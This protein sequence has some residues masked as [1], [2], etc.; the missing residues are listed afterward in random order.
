M[1]ETELNDRER[2]LTTLIRKLQSSA[3]LRPG[4]QVFCEQDWFD[5]DHEPYAHFAHYRKPR[6]GDL[7]IGQTGRIDRWKIGFYVSGSGNGNHV[8]RDINT[9]QLCNYGNEEFV[10]I[11][12]LSKTDLLTGEERKVY[13]K[14]LK[15]FDRGDEYLYRFGGFEVEGDTITITIRERHNGMGQPS[16]PFAVRMKWN[17]RTTVKAILE[18]M[19]QGGYGTKSFRPNPEAQEA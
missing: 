14:V 4:A 16:V 17:K 6:C 9:G 15:A 2:I 8:I 1:A 5:R 18:G 3:L 12:G 19:R 10:P 11:V 7:V 13:I